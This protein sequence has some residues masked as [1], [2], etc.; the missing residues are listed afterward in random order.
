MKK[1]LVV[2]FCF[3]MLYPTIVMSDMVDKVYPWELDKR[4][5][6][7]KKSHKVVVST[8]CSK[9]VYEV[10]SFTYEGEFNIQDVWENWEDRGESPFKHYLCFIRKDPNPNGIGNME[11]LGTVL[12]DKSF[13]IVGYRYYK[14]DIEYRYLRIEIPGEKKHRYI[15]ILPR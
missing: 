10:K 14:N 4:K 6:P 8:N 15:Q 9:Q 12:S 5:S 1:L 13:F 7:E 3:M 2:I 11:V